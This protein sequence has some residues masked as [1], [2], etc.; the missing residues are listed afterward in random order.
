MNCADELCEFEITSEIL[1]HSRVLSALRS[2]SGLLVDHRLIEYDRGVGIF[3]R[4]ALGLPETFLHVI[5]AQACMGL[6]HIDAFVLEQ[7][8]R[9]FLKVEETACD[10]PVHVALRADKCMLFPRGVGLNA[11]YGDELNRLDILR[12]TDYRV[13]FQAFQGA[14]ANRVLYDHMSALLRTEGRDF[15]LEA[16]PTGFIPEGLKVVLGNMDTGSIRIILSLLANCLHWSGL[17][18]PTQK[19]SVCKA[20][21]STYHF[22]SCDRQFLDGREWKIFLALARAEA[23]EEF[24]NFTFDVLYRWVSDTEL[25]R[26]SY[27][28]TVLE[29]TSFVV[30][31]PFRW[32][33]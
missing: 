2:A 19:C 5:V 32:I 21:P 4:T 10:G 26:P 15:W 8:T 30:S 27:R 1:P 33:L 31:D 18:A 7:R 6:K 28:L 11:L 23:W 29:F 20:K 12:T 24:V 22:F 17:V 13:L 25:F 3:F 9:F 14:M 16:L